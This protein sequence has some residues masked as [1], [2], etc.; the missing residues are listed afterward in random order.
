MNP[1]GRVRD[2]LRRRALHRELRTLYGSAGA[3]PAAPVLSGTYI[4]PETAI[5]LAAVFAAV[6]VISRDVAA[7]PRHVYKRLPRGGRAID[8]A[9]PVERLLN[10]QPNDE[11]DAF[12]FVQS[13]MGHVLTRGNWYAEIVRDKDGR[14]ES[15]HLLHPSKTL[16]KRTE[17][18]R[19]LYYQLNDGASRDDNKP[20]PTLWPEDVLHFAGLG[21][22]GL[23]GYSPVTLARQTIGLGMAVEQYGAAFFG[24][25][26]IP[27]GILKLP[28]KLTE[29]A[30]NN[31]R[32]SLNQI[33]QGSQSAHQLM[34]L[35]Q[36]VD[37]A[38]T[39]FSPED[40][41]FL[42]TREFQVK[43]VARLYNLPPHKI[44]DYS[45]SHLASAEEANLDY[46]TMTLTGW[47]TMLEA[48]L[49]HKLL[50]A[51]EQQTHFIGV[52][53]TALLR[54]NSDARMKGY[55][56]MR[57]MGAISA[58]EIRTAEGMNPIGPDEGGDLYLVQGQYVPLD[59]VGEQPAA[60][61]ADQAGPDGPA[62]GKR[63]RRGEGTGPAR[64]YFRFPS[65][66]EYPATPGGFRSYLTDCSAHPLLDDRS[67]VVLDFDRFSN[68]YNHCHGKDGRF[69]SGKG[70][71]GGGGGSAHAAAGGGD[72]SPAKDLGD[73]S[74]KEIGAH[75]R[76]MS[77][78]WKSGLSQG[79]HD[80]FRTYTGESYGPINAQLRSG[81]GAKAPIVKEM[82][83]A[84]SKASLSE[85][86]VVYRGVSDPGKLGLGGE[87]S[88]GTTIRDPAFMSTSVNGK[89]AAKYAGKG[90]AV[91]KITA[92]KGAH[93][94]SMGG[95]SRYPKEH[96]VL[97]ARGSGVRITKVTKEGGRTVYHG[98][99]VQ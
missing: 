18:S 41:Q 40:G 49:N 26:A 87:K 13:G 67:A 52:D 16:I 25:S 15:L 76:E 29:A 57:N 11:Q 39:Q 44:G 3:V 23:I 80:A 54:G 59:K 70:G 55:Q 96:E 1:L 93:G 48:Q 81:Q 56:L 14:P 65:P 90:G 88:V 84:M 37:W 51:E 83:A 79:E 6:N 82:D 69:C 97:F 91:L 60:A 21:F 73:K 36:G 92:P 71:K 10:V 61:P 30:V 34:I 17:G 66:C 42:L 68:R 53:M 45:E 78:S 28:T 74:D 72:S 46:L 89:L 99:L 94:A 31:L 19:R 38:Q 20:P 7:L 35:E 27:K 2:W 62:D 22:D 9:H 8:H 47:I 58:D 95:I 32:R 63:A 86:T 4:T 50:T 5:C 85:K 24:N 98:E 43:E 75:H 33:H 64:D 77:A 12:R